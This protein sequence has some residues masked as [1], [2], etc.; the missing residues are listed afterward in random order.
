MSN[1]SLDN[2]GV[3]CALSVAFH[4]SPNPHLQMLTPATRNH[5]DSD[6]DTIPHRLPTH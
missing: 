4:S 3:L 5:Y 1:Y 2:D 6:K